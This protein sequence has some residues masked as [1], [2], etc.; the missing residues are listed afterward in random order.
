[1]DRMIADL[2]RYLD[3]TRSELEM[4]LPCCIDCLCILI[5]M[6]HDLILPTISYQSSYVNPASNLQLTNSDLLSEDRSCP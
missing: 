5:S 2:L 1:M 4:V 3:N 6:I